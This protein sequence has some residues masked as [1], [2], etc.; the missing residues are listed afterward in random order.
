MDVDGEEDTTQA[1]RE[2]DDYGLVID[3]SGVDEEDLEVSAS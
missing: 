2:V 1:I 3:F